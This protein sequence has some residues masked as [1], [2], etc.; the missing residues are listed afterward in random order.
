MTLSSRSVGLFDR[1]IAAPGG[2][3]PTPSGSPILTAYRCPRGHLIESSTIRL[4]GPD[5]ADDFEVEG[6]CANCWKFVEARED[7]VTEQDLAE[8]AEL[9]LRALID[10]LKEVLGAMHMSAQRDAT[11]D[12]PNPAL[13]QG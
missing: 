6:F 10:G 12:G 8:E 4:E 5:H 3:Q 7:H 1:A 11:L 2:G 13:D 9:Q